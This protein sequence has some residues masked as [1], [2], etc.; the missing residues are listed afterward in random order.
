MACHITIKLIREDLV[1][2]RDLILIEW[3][4]HIYLDYHELQT[5]LAIPGDEEYLSGKWGQLETSSDEADKLQ[6]AQVDDD[7]R[8]LQSKVNYGKRFVVRIHTLVS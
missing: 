5:R 2:D 8:R 6:V 1:P 7:L 4:P 3:S